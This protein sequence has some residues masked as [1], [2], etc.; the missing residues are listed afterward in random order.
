MGFKGQLRLTQFGSLSHDSRRGHILATV[1]AGYV[2]LP[3]FL[4]SELGSVIVFQIPVPDT[5]GYGN[6]TLM[7]GCVRSQSCGIM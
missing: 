5:R 7:I 3:R 4:E 6:M 1:I 2:M